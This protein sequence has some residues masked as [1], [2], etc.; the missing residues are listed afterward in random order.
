VSFLIDLHA[1]NS[2]HQAGVLIVVPSFCGVANLHQE[3]PVIIELEYG[4]VFPRFLSFLRVSGKPDVPRLINKYA[5]LLGRPVGSVSGS[6]PGLDHIALFVEFQYGRRRNTTLSRW[7]LLCRGGFVRRETSWSLVNPNVIV[8]V[9]RHSAD[10]SHDPVVWQLFLA[11]TDPPCTW[12][13][14]GRV[15]LQ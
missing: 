4:S 6:T 1:G 2:S 15:P 9:D 5:V 13:R 11:R 3:L 8:L 7:R 14:P 12:A 10:L